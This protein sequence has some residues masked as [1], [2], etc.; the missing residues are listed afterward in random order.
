[1]QWNKQDPPEC[2]HL[3]IASLADRIE[4]LIVDMRVL[5]TLQGQ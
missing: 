5:P 2:R 1:M 4:I 3:P